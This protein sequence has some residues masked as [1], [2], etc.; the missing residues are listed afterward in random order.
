MKYLF[1]ILIFFSVN[2]FASSEPLRVAVVQDVPFVIRGKE[3]YSG[4]AIDLWE[5]VAD[6]M[7]VTYKYYGYPVE[8]LNQ[9][10]KDLEEGRIDI[11]VAPLAP[12]KDRYKKVD[13]TIPFFLDKVVALSNKGYSNNLFAFAYLFILCVF[14]L[15]VVLTSLIFIYVNILWFSERH[16]SELIPKN[17][18]KG[19]EYLFWQH[20]LKGAP[21]EVPRTTG[22]KVAI[23]FQQFGIFVTAV[24]VN[25]GFVSYVTAVLVNYES[26]VMKPDDL[27]G[28]L[29]GAAR[30]TKAFKI[31]FDRGYRVEPYETIDQGIEALENNEVKSFVGDYTDIETFLKSHPKKDLD[32]SHFNL[33]WDLYA[34][35]VPI[36]S[37][38]RREVNIQLL[39]MRAKGIPE[40]ILRSYMPQDVSSSEL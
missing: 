39:D 14:F 17:Y 5:Q 31:A 33:S 4:V 29:L 13:Y 1:L 22:G 18:K 24:L 20:L 32:V 25:A 40:Q 28:V 21:D 2:C 35:A 38:L 23:L 3:G 8:K 26:P 15:A 36:G 7:K 9:A 12:N 30:N 34:F 11:F 6:R 10:F 37:P 27:K 19:L 16:H